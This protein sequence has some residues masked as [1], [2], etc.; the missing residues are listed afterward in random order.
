MVNDLGGSQTLAACILELCDVHS[1]I[2]APKQPK[3]SV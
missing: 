1:A 3:T 2:M